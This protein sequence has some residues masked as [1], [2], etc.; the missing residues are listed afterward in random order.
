LGTTG[1][2]DVGRGQDPRVLGSIAQYYVHLQQ[3]DSARIWLR[4]AEA[5]VDSS[6]AGALLTFGFGELY[7]SMGRRDR[8]VA[9]IQRALDQQ[10]G[11][12]RLR[13]SPWLAGLRT[14]PRLRPHLDAPR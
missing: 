3:P 1:P 4:R 12:I 2:D 13:H 9:W 6:T 14:D 7:E 10:Y 8:A 11:A 5:R